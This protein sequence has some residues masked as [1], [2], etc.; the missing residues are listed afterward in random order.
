MNQRKNFIQRAFN[1]VIEGRQRH[2]NF[3]VAK[4]RKRYEQ[5]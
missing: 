1:A 5:N 3:E 2:A 4:Y